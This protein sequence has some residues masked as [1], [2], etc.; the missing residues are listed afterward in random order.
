[1]QGISRTVLAEEM[2]FV[3]PMP[4]Y[5]AWDYLMSNELAQGVGR[6]MYYTDE[7]GSSHFAKTELISIC[8]H[9]SAAFG[10]A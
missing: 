5:K 9:L 7:I 6:Q 3:Q 4:P 1:M 2:P 8:Q 10:P